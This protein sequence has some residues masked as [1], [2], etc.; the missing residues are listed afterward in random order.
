VTHPTRTVRG[1]SVVTLL[2][3]GALL[4]LSYVLVRATLPA[5]GPFAVTAIRTLIGGLILLLVA[6]LAGQ[7]VRRRDWRAY[8]T[9]GALSAAIPFSLTSISML[10]IDAGSAAVLNTAAP[11]FALAL[12]SVH[13][14]RWPGAGKVVG[15]AVATVG[16]VVVMDAR[17]VHIERSG[18]IGVAFALAGACVF[19][20]AGFFAARKFTTTTPLA[21]AAGQQLAACVLLLPVVAARPPAG[22]VDRTVAVRLL[23]LGVLGGALAYLLFYWLIAHEGPVFTSNVSLLI[24]VCGVLWGWALLGEALP[25]LSL[26]GMVFVVAGL[27]LVV[28]PTP[29]VPP[30]QPGFTTPSIVDS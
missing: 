29:T 28:R 22:P 16:V 27:A 8:V 19:A 17:G 1:R 2:C 25:A 3:C 26:I 21:V 6:Q 5:V 9:L 20:Y 24:P 10:S 15:L 30:V 12:D 14:R 7:P 23:V 11:M 4:G 13:Q 18:L